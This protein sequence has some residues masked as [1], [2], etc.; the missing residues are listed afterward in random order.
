MYFM[1]LAV[2]F[3][4]LFNPEGRSDTFFQNIGKFLENY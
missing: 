1:L 3:G 2:L 4:L